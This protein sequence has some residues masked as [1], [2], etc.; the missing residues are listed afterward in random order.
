MENKNALPVAATTKQDGNENN[1]Q[2][3]DITFKCG[4]SIGRIAE[5]MELIDLFNQQFNGIATLSLTSRGADI[6]VTMCHVRKSSY[7]CF[8]TEDAFPASWHNVC[9]DADLVK[10]EAFMKMLIRAADHC[11]AMRGFDYEREE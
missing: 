8:E 7:K 6:H 10:A 11:E 4:L 2:V 3:N 9:G 5:L 1:H